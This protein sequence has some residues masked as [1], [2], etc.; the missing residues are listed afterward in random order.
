MKRV[1]GY[2]VVVLALSSP[3]F[4]QVDLSG[5]WASRLH[6]DYIDRGPGSDLADY[7]G[8]PLSDE[9]R[10]KGLSYDPS[11]YAME[12]RMCLY[13]PWQVAS[14]LPQGI[15]IWSELDASGR[16]IAWHVGGSPERDEL[17]IWMDG[18]PHPSPNA[19]HPF[20]GFTTGRWEGDTLTTLTTH[21]KSGYTRRANGIPASDRATVTAHFTRH[22]NLLTVVTIQEDPVYLTEPFVVSRTWQLDPRG[23]QGV[24]STCF[25]RAEI[26]RFEDT[27][28]VPHYLP[29][30]E[31]P[32]VQFMTD[33]YK[34]PKEV[35][36][37]Y[38][39]TLYPEY[40][41]KLKGTYTPPVKCERYCCGWIEAQGR[42]EAAPNLMCRTAGS[43]GQ[44]PSPPVDGGSSD[45]GP[46]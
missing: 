35:T 33:T 12:E 30:D 37:G 42:P 43:V 32:N 4:A 13:A 25:S 38:A 5:V 44:A 1:C 3:A 15:R 41:L 34:V 29:G 8:V 45:A 20:S 6:E 23:N 9:G 11:T 31:S 28:V 14:F 39:E 40:R 26:Q 46:R 22:D 21:L 16:L 36:L 7:M 24:R 10:A 2:V 18:R 19:F 27:G 17:T